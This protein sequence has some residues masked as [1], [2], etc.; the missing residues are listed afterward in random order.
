MTAFAPLPGLLEEVPD[1]CRA[2]GKVYQLA[3]VLLSSMLA[4]ISGGNSYRIIVTFIEMH[5]PRL[6]GVF[7]LTWQRTPAHAAIRYTL[8]GLDSNAVEAAFRGHA[9]LL[10]AAQVKPNGDS[11]AIDGKTLR[12][13]SLGHARRSALPE[14][15]FDLTAKAG[16][17]L[18]IQVKDNQPILHQQAKN[19]CASAA[20]LSTSGSCNRGRNRQEERSVTAFDAATAFTD[21]EC[22]SL[23]GAVIRVERAALTRSARTG[24]WPRS[25]KTAFY[26]ATAAIPAIRAASA[27]R[28]HWKVENTSHYI[29]DVTIGEDRSRIRRNPGLFARLRSFA[30]NTLRANRRSS[31]P[32]DRLRAAIGGVDYLLPPQHSTV[33]NNPGA[34]CV[35]TDDRCNRMDL[36]SSPGRRCRGDRSEHHVAALG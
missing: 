15:T 25:S 36:R 14:E 2:E 10:Q 21:T 24:L 18:I 31:L 9:K 4:I 34:T 35:H 30:F 28:D 12:G 26:L 5:R 6:N 17:D 13:S 23:I 8:Q 1:H 16:S 7:G 3:F 22:A 32:Q 27:I 20:P 29:R 11:P 33:L 19:L